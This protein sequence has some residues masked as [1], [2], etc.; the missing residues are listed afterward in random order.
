MH[1]LSPA[2][3]VVCAGCGALVSRPDFVVFKPSSAGANN[4]TNQ[5][6][7]VVPTPERSFLAFWTQ[8]SQE[9]DPNQRVVMSRS[10]D[11]GRSWS[12]P[13]V[14]AGD[15]TGVSGRMASWQ[16][17]VVVPFT[18]RVYLFWN[19]NVG[20]VDA[21]E[22]TTGVLSYRWSDDDGRTWSKVCTLPIRKSAIS[23]PDPDIPENWVVYQCPVITSGGE[24]IV[25][26]TRWA[27]RVKQP[28]GGLFD[29]DSE[30]WFLRFDNILSEPDPRKLKV[31]TLPDGDR[32]LRVSRPGSPEMSIAQEPT[33]QELRDGRFICVMR[34]Y[35]GFVHYALSEDR[36]H[37]WDTP[38]PLRFAPQGPKIRQPL[39]SCP[40]YLLKDGRLLLIFHNNSGDANGGQ[41]PA[42]SRR[43]RRPVFVAV[44]REIAHKDH[45][46]VF[47]R[48]RMIADNGGRPTGPS[49]HTQIGTYPS[50][51]EFEGEVYFWYPDRKHYLLGKILKSEDIDDAGLP[52]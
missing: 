29:R 16:F 26:F 1:W 45:P 44:G 7:L 22:D 2:L 21:R 28:E 6:F 35:T 9:N 23:N 39:A 11:T 37:S 43:N 46:V 30:V 33:L 19:Q 52:R 34:T 50:L 31:T 18:G 14:L 8:A 15:P 4:G 47:T 40:L 36:G 3:I 12:P 38:R 20:V 27:S 25:G 42:D 10:E 32:G 5:H 51:F 13:V 49:D 41:G 24:V 48:P 17:P